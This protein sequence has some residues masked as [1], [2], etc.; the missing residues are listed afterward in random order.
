M[1]AAFSNLEQQGYTI[2]KSSS[3]PKVEFNREH[4]VCESDAVRAGS[5]ALQPKAERETC[6]G[7]GRGGDVVVH[8]RIEELAERLYEAVGGR[9]DEHHNPEWGWCGTNG[10]TYSRTSDAGDAA[11]E[12]IV[13]RGDEEE[14][15]AER[16]NGDGDRG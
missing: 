4:R 3:S 10:G 8:D 9:A 1:E 2:G 13:E 14:F 11:E 5:R 12:E 7:A 6:P 15:G 16:R